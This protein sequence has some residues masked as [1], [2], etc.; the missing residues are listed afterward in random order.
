MR[1]L[2]IGGNDFYGLAVRHGWSYETIDLEAEQALVWDRV[3]HKEGH[4]RVRHASS[5]LDG[6]STC[7]ALRGMAQRTRPDLSLS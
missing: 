4:A 7:A 2:D 6:A 3:K 1:V 5:C